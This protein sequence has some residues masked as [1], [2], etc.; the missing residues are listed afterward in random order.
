MKRWIILPAV[1]ILFLSACSTLKGLNGSYVRSNT[2]EL[3]FTEDPNRFEYFLRGEMGL[4]QYSAGEWKRN[5]NKV[6]LTGFTDENIQAIPVESDVV[7]D[8]GSNNVQVQVF[9]HTDKAVTY[10]RSVIILNDDS[11]YTLAK[12]TIF[13][14]GRKVGTVQVKSY[15]SY[16]G[17]LSSHPKT[18]TLYSRKI[19][20]DGDTGDKIVLKF[21][22]YSKDFVRIALADTLTVKNSRTL[23]YNKINLK[24]SPN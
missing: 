1:S 8:A 13:A 9:Y 15:L 10:I 23:R 7:R 12:D 5:G 19:R 24:R 6:Y 2:I 3:R 14:F 17:L 16:Q 18:D 20:V 11:I 4:L 22:V 21:S